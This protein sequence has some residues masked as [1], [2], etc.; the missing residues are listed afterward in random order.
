[1]EKNNAILL[2]KISRI[3]AKDPSTDMLDICDELEGILKARVASA[4]AEDTRRH[5]SILM[6]G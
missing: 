5:I 3:R 4:T 6:G 2:D 1:M